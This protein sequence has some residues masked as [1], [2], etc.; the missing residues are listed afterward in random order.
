[1]KAASPH[2]SAKIAL[3]RPIAIITCVVHKPVL[4]FA[5]SIIMVLNV[6]SFGTAGSYFWLM[7]AS[8]TDPN[9]PAKYTLKYFDVVRT[10][11]AKKSCVDMFSSTFLRPNCCI[12]VKRF[13]FGW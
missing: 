12:Q 8:I 10:K 7:R 5:F 9:F 11:I 13:K 6:L 1:M 2:W 3:I 4:H